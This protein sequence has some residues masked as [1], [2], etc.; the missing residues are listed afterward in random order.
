M[1]MRS[2]PFRHV[3]LLGMNDGEYPRQQDP[4]SFDLMRSQLNGRS[5]YRPGDRARRDD[6][7]YLFLEALLSARDSL[8]ISWTGR[9]QQDNTE[10]PPSVLV[11]QLR[12]AIDAYWELGTSAQLTV[13]HAVQPFSERYF[14]QG[15][16]TL[17]AT[18]AKEWFALHQEEEV[19]AEPSTGAEAITPPKEITVD[20]LSAFLKQPVA[21]F[22]S[23]RLGV[24]LRAQRSEEEDTEPFTFDGLASWQLE[25]ALVNA[26]LEGGAQGY[27][28]AM[29]QQ[30]EW[31][32]KAGELPMGEFADVLT[33][34][35]VMGTANTASAFFASVGDGKPTADKP[36]HAL[37]G[38]TTVL[39]NLNHLYR[40]QH[41]FSRQRMV[42][43]KINERWDKL[44]HDWALH[45]LACAQG[46]SLT[47]LVY[48]QDTVA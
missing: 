2:I 21:F 42:P 23:H 36:L 32:V 43:G 10:L 45:L 33:H 35:K 7:R 41:R 6:D 15:E 34:P 13:E 38:A 19:E 44:V 29:V 46:I 48:G 14:V 25:N 18:Y 26:A 9:S 40:Y 31:L 4:L 20:T 24:Y 16:D 30:V 39:G 8:Y 47:T 22:F 5:L 3:C 28:A 11:A 1:P 12:D 37:L 27:E 17:P